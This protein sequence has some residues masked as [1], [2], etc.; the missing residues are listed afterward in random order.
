MIRLALA[1]V[2]AAGLAMAEEAE[3][4]RADGATVPVRL[5][6]DWTTP[7]CPPTLILSHGLGGTQASLGWLDAPALAAGFRVLAM[8][9][10][11][12]GPAALWRVARPSDPFAALAAPSFWAARA[13][14]L[15]AAIARATT[16]CR[17]RPF[18]LGGHSMGAALTVIEAGSRSPLPFDGRARFDAYIA[19]SPQGI[20]WAFE[21][22]DAW[23]GIAAPI[24]M[25]TGTRDTVGAEDW[26]GRLAAFAGLP[27][28]RKRLAVIEGAGHVALAGRLMPRTVRD[29]AR[30]VAGEYLMH[31]R[32]GW[33][34]SALA[35]RPGLSVTD[36]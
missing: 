21:R 33:R 28:G 26:R 6:G 34:P 19:I 29:A 35:G 31:L 3:L 14:D 16:H 27:P 8:G 15:D 25:L 2:L 1:L 7:G 12:T 10:A 5:A 24:L 9:H 30:A 17:P 32:T 4:P 22:A 18:V 23:A 11:E 13:A 20:G 36:K